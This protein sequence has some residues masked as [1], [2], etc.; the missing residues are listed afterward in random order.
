MPLP[1]PSQGDFSVMAEGIDK[2][3]L[4]VFDVA[5]RLVPQIPLTNATQEKV[6]RLSQGHILS[7][8]QDK[9]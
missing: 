1:I 2:D 6:N 7:G 5:R 9:T 4:Q 3:M 8:W